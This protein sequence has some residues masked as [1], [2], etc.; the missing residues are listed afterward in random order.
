MYQ[1]VFYLFLLIFASCSH[2]DDDFTKPELP[3]A[4]ASAGIYY[5]PAPN[6]S[7]SGRSIWIAF[8]R[9]GWEFILATDDRS[10]TMDYLDAGKP[11]Q[12]IVCCTDVFIESPG[13]WL[14][15]PECGGYLRVY[16]KTGRV[17]G[18]IGKRPVNL[19]PDWTP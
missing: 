2:A 9:Q 14:A 19:N 8:P 7:V 10:I 6:V 16:S 5:Q 18:K 11:V 1:Y 4:E 15:L 13:V 17:C 12:E 3:R